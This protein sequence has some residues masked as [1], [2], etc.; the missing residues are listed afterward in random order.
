[1]PANMIT[2]FTCPVTGTVVYAGDLPADWFTINDEVFSPEAKLP[3]A[4][5]ILDHPDV[6]LEELLASL[7]QPPNDP[8]DTST[9]PQ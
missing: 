1:M 9:D 2:R 3:L 5:Y 6:G 8:A 7:G 4:Q